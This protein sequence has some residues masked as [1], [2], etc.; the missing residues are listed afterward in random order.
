MFRL[1][2][3]CIRYSL[4]VKILKC[5][6]KINLIF[7]DSLNVY[8]S[9]CEAV[10]HYDCPKFIKTIY[11]N[12]RLCNL[13]Q[14]VK[15]PIYVY[16]RTRIWS[17]SGNVSFDGETIYSGMVRWGFNWGYRSN[18]VTIIR[19]EGNIT[20]K[21]TCLIAKASDIAVFN[22][23]F[24]SIGNGVEILENTLIY[25]QDRISIGDNFSFAFQ[26]SMFDTD[27][28]YM[29]NVNELKIS[30][31]S[32]PIIIGDNVWIGNRTTIK[33]GVIIPNNTIVAASYSVLTKD[34]SSI[35]KYSVLGGCP[36]K[37]IATGY[38]RIWRDE[39]NNTRMLEDFFKKS[40]KNIYHITSKKEKF[41]FIYECK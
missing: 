6:I 31:K 27:F 15:C 5:F 2:L 12:S 23:A 11:F 10:W 18:G 34:Y 26:S 1:F 39:L 21:G 3:T 33:K 13:Q 32:A 25:C 19:I 20:F 38:S 14:A 41:D 22:E 8:L 40:H 24:L 36:A 30:P 28:H 29:V 16:G 7:T 9:Y 35:P 17:L 37:V 4:I